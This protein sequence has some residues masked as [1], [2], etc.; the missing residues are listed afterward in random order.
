MPCDLFLQRLIVP[1]HNHTVSHIDQIATYP[2]ITIRR[3]RVIVHGAIAEY[4]DVRRV[5]E[6]G[7]ATAVVYPALRI[8]R[9]PM[10]AGSQHVEQAPL[11]VGAAV[12]QRSQALEMSVPITP[13]GARQ[14]FAGSQIQE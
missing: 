9:Q 11:Y 6:V 3:C 10:A 5:E 7:D 2:P 12:R 8:V 1:D 14:P 13:A 4:A